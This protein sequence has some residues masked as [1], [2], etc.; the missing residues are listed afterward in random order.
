MNL[1][2]LNKLNQQRILVV[3]DIMVDSYIR[4]TVER[5]S[6]E[7]PVPVI[8]TK[9]S[10]GE[11]TLGGA[12]NVFNNLLSLG[13]DPKNVMLYGIIAPDE[14]GKFVEKYLKERDC[15]VNGLTFNH[16]SRTTTKIRLVGNHQHVARVDIE[17]NEP[18]APYMKNILIQ[19]LKDTIL[20]SHIDAVIISDYEKG[21]L[22]EEIISII[23]EC[24]KKKDIYIACD[25][26][27]INFKYY[28]GCD[29][30]TPNKKEA[31]TFSKIK[32][33]TDTAA[34][35]AAEYIISELGCTKVLLKL[36]ED[37]ILIYNKETIKNVK[38]E[39]HEVCDVT[40]A[41]DTVIATYVSAFL[42]GY[43]GVTAATIANKAASLVIQESGTT[44]ITVEK[45]IKSF[46]DK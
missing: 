35:C 7:A 22:D 40:G 37:G 29:V 31:E 16:T 19:S 23:L 14:S 44:V 38:E 6:P 45:L 32:I 13:C 10:F 18:L 25:P 15:S 39:V 26:K 46:E 28:K 9:T 5:I 20:K 41:G 1:N 33:D 43:D 34:R 42:C 2:K 17:D 36:G 4:G 21:V 12:G 27:F 30:I 3:G 8:K 11:R 24:A